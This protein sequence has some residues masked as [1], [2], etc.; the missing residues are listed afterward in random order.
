MRFALPAIAAALALA[1][2]API[3][4]EHV[5]AQP[6]RP[7]HRRDDRRQ[8]IE[9]LRTELGYYQQAYA[10]LSA[11][12]DRADRANRRNRDRRSMMQIDRALR[13]ARDRAAQYVQ[14]WTNEQLEPDWRDNRDWRSLPQTPPPGGVRDRRSPEPAPAPAPYAMADRDFRALTDQVGRASF[15]DDKLAVVQT[16][17][18]TNYFTVAQVIALMQLASFDDT[19]VEIAAACAPRVIDGDKW[20][21]VYGAL[22][23]SSSRDTLR[24]RVGGR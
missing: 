5:S 21:E 13:D 6:G 19:R 16:A 20:F 23:F 15:A 10:E 7:D 9:Q 14:P 1:F 11:G 12:L 3:V 17:A 24:N 22:S 8:E 18:Q 4:A 2:T